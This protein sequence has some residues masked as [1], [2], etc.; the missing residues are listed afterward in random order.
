MG[1]HM[2]EEMKAVE[3]Q[4]NTVE[5]DKN[6]YNTLKDFYQEYYSTKKVEEIPIEKMTLSEKQNLFSKL[7]EEINNDYVSENSHKIKR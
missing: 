6:E 2:S 4:K 3:Q 1:D 5:V 7:I